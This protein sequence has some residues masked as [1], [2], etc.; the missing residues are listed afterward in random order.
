MRD[1]ELERHRGHKPDA[2]FLAVDELLD[3]RLRHLALAVERDHDPSRLELDRRQPQRL[4]LQAHL[5]DFK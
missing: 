5:H 1:L 4:G 3:C 2:G